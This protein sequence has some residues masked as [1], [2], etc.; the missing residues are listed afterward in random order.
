MLGD[1]KNTTQ[2]KPKLNEKSLKS[3]SVTKIRLKT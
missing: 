3:K 1:I 2:Q